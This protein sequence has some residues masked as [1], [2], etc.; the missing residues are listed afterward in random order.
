MSTE[1]THDEV[2]RHYS[3]LFKIVLI[4]LDSR[5]LNYTEIPFWNIINN[6]LRSGIDPS[7]FD[8][9][10]QLLTIQ[11]SLLDGR[12]LHHHEESSK[13]YTTGNENTVK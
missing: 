6:M 8:L 13:E 2:L 10:G 1:M 4:D 12:N 3:Q 7:V 11:L 5:S 9:Q